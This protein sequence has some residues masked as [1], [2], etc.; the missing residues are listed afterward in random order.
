MIIALSIDNTR[1]ATFGLVTF[2]KPFSF[3]FIGKQDEVLT[4]EGRINC[5]R[6]RRIG[7]GK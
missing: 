4:E 3:V 1:D 5:A 2:S 6:N 7:A